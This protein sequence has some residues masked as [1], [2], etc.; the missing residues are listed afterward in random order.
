MFRDIPGYEGLYSIAPCG[1]IWIKKRRRFKTW[2]P[3]YSGKSVYAHT[4]LHKNGQRKHFSIHRLVMLAFVGPSK[5]HVNHKDFNTLNN[6]IDNLEYVTAK[7][8]MEHARAGGRWQSKLYSYLPY[9]H[10]NRSFTYAEIKYI[11]ECGKTVQELADEFNTP[12]KRIRH[13]LITS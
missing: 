12:P 2:R 8:N 9:L 6:H 10:P 13:V 7:E 11:N 3:M 4:Y 1:C 5:L